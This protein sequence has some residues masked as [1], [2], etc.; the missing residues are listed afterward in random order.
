MVRVPNSPTVETLGVIAIVFTLQQFAGLFG[1]LVGISGFALGFFALNLPLTV[2]PWT[3]VTSVY[4]HVGLVHL[5][6]NA[7]VLLIVGLVV[8]SVTD[9]TRYHLFFLA[10][11]VLAGLTEVVASGLFG[12]PTGV[13]GASGAIFGLVGYVLAANPVS[14]TILDR[15]RLRRRVQFGLFVL[16]AVGLT[17][18]TGT[19]GAALI[20]H[21]VGLLVGLLAGRL[22]LLHAGEST[23]TNTAG[24]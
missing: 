10:T 23:P 9:R 12:Q 7:V 15:L 17:L 20:A 18:I 8:E 11:G 2:Y 1:T 6:S 22:R 16:F 19:A 14:E 5:L 13:L 21:F 24:L 4:A 3:L